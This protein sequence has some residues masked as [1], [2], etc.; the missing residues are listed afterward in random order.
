M[1]TW[2]TAGGFGMVMVAIVGLVAT[3][4][5]GRVAAA[6]TEG[7]LR[8]LRLAP[9]LI[10]ALAMLGFGMNLWTV[11]RHVASAPASA[12]AIVGVLEA[13]QPLTL[14]AGFVVVVVVLGMLAE[15]RAAR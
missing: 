5:A 3:F 9:V 15:G 8:M 1:I 2:F 13:A 11:Y 10:G 4:G 6:P 12:V 7:A 14:G